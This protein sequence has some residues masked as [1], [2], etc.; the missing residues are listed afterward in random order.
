MKTNKK[1][2]NPYARKIVLS[3]KLNPVEMQKFLSKS[4]GK[5]KGNMSAM[6]RAA[7]EKY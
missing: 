2:P 6:I 4:I 3:F 7:V 1:K 5:H